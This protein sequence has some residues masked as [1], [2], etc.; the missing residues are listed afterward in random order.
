MDLEFCDWSVAGSDV[1]EDFEDCVNEGTTTTA[2]VS[3]GCVVIVTMTVLRVPP[4]VDADSVMTEVMTCV[5][6]GIEDA[7][8]DEVTTSADDGGDVDDCGEVDDGAA[9]EASEERETGVELGEE[10][11]ATAEE[12]M[13]KM[14]DEDTGGLVEDAVK[15]SKEVVGL[16]AVPLLLAPMSNKTEQRS[17][18]KVCSA[19]I[20]SVAFDRSSVC[21]YQ[22]RTRPNEEGLEC[23]KIALSKE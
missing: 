20:G 14:E 19:W 22:I 1:D 17:C 18:K 6:G 4:G 23:I 12:V 13:V 3:E 9:V 15:E 11:V 7:A 21:S 2:D 5:D 10:D 8:I 16:L